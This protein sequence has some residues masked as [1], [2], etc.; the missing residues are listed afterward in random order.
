LTDRIAAWHKPGYAPDIMTSDPSLLVSPFDPSQTEAVVPLLELCFP[1]EPPQN[2]PH[3]YLARKLSYQPDFVFVA[4]LGESIVGSIVGG[5]DGVRGWMYHVATHPEFRRQGIATQLV[6]KL[7]QALT[8]AGCPKLNLQI[9]STNH[10]VAAFY[11][12]L[13]YL[14]EDRLSFGRKL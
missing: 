5:Y 2:E 4:Q 13:G 10:E 14:E 12:A 8:A 3:A 1:D 6:R 11:E 7:E 9:R